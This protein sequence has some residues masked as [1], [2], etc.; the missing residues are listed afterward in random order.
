MPENRPVS[1][2]QTLT[3]QITGYGH[4][5]EGVGRY[6]NFTVFVNGAIRG[7]EVEVRISEVHR[8]FARANTLRI[9]NPAPE[10]V[11]P[12]CPLYGRCGGCQLLHLAYPAQLEL[13]RQR[14][15]D[16]LTRLGGLADVPVRPPVGMDDPWHYRNKVQYPVALVDGKIVLGCYERYSHR[17]VP[18]EDC[19]IQQEVNNRL[20]RAVR[21]LAQEWRLLPYDERTGRGFLRHVLIKSAA[22]T[23]EA[24][25]V[26]VTNGPEFPR[27]EE[28]GAALAA[29]VPQLVGLAQ[30]INLLRTNVVL[31]RETRIL[32]GKEAI[33][34]EVGGVRFRVSA[35]SFFQ[36][37]PLQTEVLYER[38]LAYAGLTGKEMVLD[39][40]CGVGS[41]T[42][43][44]ARQARRVY[45]VEVVE[46]AIHDAEENARLNGI[47]NVTF[48]VGEAERVLP[49]LAASGTRVAPAGLDPPRAGGESGVL[50]TL[51]ATGVPRI[52]YISCNPSTLA[53]DLKLLAEEG[54]VVRE[55]QPVDMFPHT[56][57][58]ESV[59]LITRL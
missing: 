53:R 52:V 28:F 26:L 56:F 46:E 16:A 11:A 14:V 57:H 15:V 8:N 13:K 2:G 24:M 58:V 44:L 29:E 33:V 5:G 21:R 7:E 17:V 30:N 41:L 59:V 31:G 25:V 6:Q 40:Y 55:V 18:T 32:W 9:L 22:G 50:R 1:P 47:E 34:D 39:V 51:A 35:V 19:L 27:G 54:Y 49:K 37:N 10:R 38:A 36:V 45:G 12:A 23:G 3:L 43:F 48:L 4:N 20:M 42:L